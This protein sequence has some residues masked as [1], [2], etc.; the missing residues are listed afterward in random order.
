VP[1]QEPNW[2]RN[3]TYMVV[4][5]STFDTTPWDDKPQVQQENAVG[6][7][8]LSGA[9]LD[10]EDDT[11]I[12]QTEPAFVA[13]QADV[14]V[15][16]SAHVRKANPRRSPE[17]AARRLFRRGYPIIES[18][19]SGLRRGLAFIAFA[20]TTSTQF[21][22]IVRAWLRNPDFPDQGAGQDQ[23]VAALPESILCGG[24][25][26]VPAVRREPWTWVLPDMA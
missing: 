2:T 15:P 16:L 11:H 25:Y 22:F 13:N 23:L 20:R 19:E 7:H 3:G 9:S 12:V 5:V 14:R 26:F 10:L 18:S 24:Y 21:E 4:R 1:T 8:K 6:R 17:D